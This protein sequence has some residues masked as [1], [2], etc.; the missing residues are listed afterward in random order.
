M[1]ALGQNLPK[2]HVRVRSAFALRATKSQTSLDVS[3]GAKAGIRG[4]IRHLVAI[5]SS[6][7][8]RSSSDA[9]AVTQ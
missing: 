6:K 9:V 4:L 8:E 5:A 3:S 7:G 1:S 2:L